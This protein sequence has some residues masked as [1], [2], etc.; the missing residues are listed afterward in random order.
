MSTPQVLVFVPGRV[1]HGI[2]DIP[3]VNILGDFTPE[4]LGGIESVTC[5][6]TGTDGAL[7]T[8][9]CKLHPHPPSSPLA[10]TF[11]NG[12][13]FNPFNDIMFTNRRVSCETVGNYL[14][15]SETC[16]VS[17]DHQYCILEEA[18]K[19]ILFILGGVITYYLR[20]YLL[21]WLTIIVIVDNLWIPS[22]ISI[23]LAII[24]IV[25][26]PRGGNN[27]NDNTTGGEIG[28][29]RLIHTICRL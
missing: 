7:V 23:G 2:S 10:P 21:Y 12:G 9:Y 27:K 14:V 11:V 29:S 16:F 15:A 26:W 5:V 28:N 8:H 3:Q 25:L 17:L 1:A 18:P 22:E 19:L 4:T 20:Y 24:T 6:V 13:L